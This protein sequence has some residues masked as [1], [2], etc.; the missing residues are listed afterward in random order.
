MLAVV[1]AGVALAT[2]LP[3]VV[4]GGRVE[5][6]PATLVRG[7]PLTLRADE[8]GL[9]IALLACAAALVALV[10]VRRTPLERSGLLLCAGGAVGVSLVGS[11]VLLVT[12]LE[13]SNAGALLLGVAAMRP[14][15]VWVRR[16]VQLAFGV[17]HLA[18]LGLLAASLQLLNSQG[19]DDLAAL[20]PGAVGTAVALP[21]ALCGAVR[22]LAAA[23][24]SPLDGSRP[25]TAWLPV[26]AIP[27][28][29]AV[30]LRLDSVTGYSLGAV[31]HT[32]LT[33]GGLA[34][35]L[36]GAAVAARSWRRPAACGRALLV[37][38]GGQV[39][40]LVGDGATGTAT[41]AAAVG[42]GLVLAALA[43]RAWCA[44]AGS[45]NWLRASALALAAALPSGAGT[46]AL[47]AACGVEIAPG[48]AR[49]IVGVVAGL[50]GVIAAG[51][52]AA[53]VARTLALAAEEAPS[54]APPLDAAI[55]AAASLALAVVP[56][57]LLG[58]IADRIAGGARA[59]SALDAGSARGPGFGWAGGYLTVA[60][61]LAGLAAAAA[62][63]LQG[64]PRRR[65]VRLP[66]A[67]GEEAS[68]PV[69]PRWAALEAL[70]QR[71]LGGLRAI[72]AWLVRQPDLPVI[73]LA[74]LACLAWFE[75]RP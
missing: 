42:V 36:G 7:V 6:T 11:A 48:G 26:A 75:Y 38:G 44:P 60:L 66:D 64:L 37:A 4:D 50:A 29:L 53:A 68:T 72:D 58:G 8:T 32:A 14:S 12:G 10:D 56:G 74:G 62:S 19:T 34:A 18:S 3:L 23:A 69:G 1:G 47:V 25:S 21:W 54:A 41:A 17:Q 22:L 9:A 67:G 65:A 5:T 49:A 43:A 39:I 40:A 2:V 24:L 31:T 16:R 33:A 15:D 55:A 51:A 70:L 57:I 59:L 13:L 73:M 46:A 63:L 52:G 28:G 45:P 30:L 35:A 71:L 61:A 27:G 20:P